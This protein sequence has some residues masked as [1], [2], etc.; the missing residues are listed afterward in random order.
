MSCEQSACNATP[1]CLGL[2]GCDHAL[3]CEGT[4]LP[5]TQARFKHTGCSQAHPIRLACPYL[6]AD[7]LDAEQAQPLKERLA[8]P[9]LCSPLAHDDRA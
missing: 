3:E 4:A 6:Q 2:S 1:A 9:R 7:R 8:E 5:A